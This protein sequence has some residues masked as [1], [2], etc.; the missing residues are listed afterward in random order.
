MTMRRSCPGIGNDLS[1]LII[2]DQPRIGKGAAFNG[3]PGE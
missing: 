2:A 1:V 3:R